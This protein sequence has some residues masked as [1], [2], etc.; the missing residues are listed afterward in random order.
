MSSKLTQLQAITLAL[1]DTLANNRS[2]LHFFFTDSWATA[3]GLAA[4]SDQ[5][6]QQFL[7]QGCLFRV[8]NSGNLLPH[9]YRKYKSRSHMSLHAFN[10]TIQ[11]L[12][13]AFLIL[14]R[15]PH[16]TDSERGIHLTS[17]NTQCWAL[18]QGIQRNVHDPHWS[19]AAGLIEY[20][21][22]FT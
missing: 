22:G 4:W 15:V 3:S 14:F 9:R 2:H 12:S 8:K 19:Q 1:E 20:H 17:Q 16:S 13:K 7:I 11:G 6:L 5:W 21:N 10:A 18:E